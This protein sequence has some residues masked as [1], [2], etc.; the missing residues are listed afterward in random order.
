LRLRETSGAIQIWNTYIMID[1]NFE[2]LRSIGLT[3]RMALQVAS[4]TPKDVLPLCLA[5]LVEVHRETVQVH[6][7]AG[8]RGA[9]VLPRL[10]RE[11]ALQ[12]S[13]LAVGDWLLGCANIHGD[14]WIHERIEPIS[15]LVRRD[16]NGTRHPL[17][18][19]VDGALLV[20]GLDEDFNPRRLERYLALVQGVGLLPL[21]VLTKADLHASDQGTLRSKLDALRGRVPGGVDTLVLNATVPAAAEALSPYLG[22]GQTFV[23]LGSSGAGKSTLTNTLLGTQRQYTGE[24]RAHDRRGQHTTT[25][26][27]LHCLP[28]GACIIDTPGLRTLRPDIDEQ[29]LTASFADVGALAAQCRFRNCTHL[30]EPGCAVREGVS[31]DRLRNYHKLLREARR[32]TMSALERQ[33]QLALWKTR[34]KMGEARAKSKRGLG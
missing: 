8:E 29:A 26:R 27:S 34:G 14:W 22:A 13:A 17:A 23:L 31:T 11:L 21:I 6:D 12:D 24:V 19:N 32:D 2:L 20:M 4:T 3:E 18:N 1:F 7:G 15:Q 30:Q 10:V 28:T 5:R 16:A 9:R 33:Q 25:S